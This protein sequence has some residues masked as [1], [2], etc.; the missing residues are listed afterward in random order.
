MSGTTFAQ[1]E[2]INAQ[3]RREYA[4]GAIQERRDHPVNLAQQVPGLKFQTPI[5]LWQMPRT[6]GPYHAT[7]ENPLGPPPT[8][9]K[10][11]AMKWRTDLPYADPNKQR[12]AILPALLLGGALL[13]AASRGP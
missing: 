1:E 2:A 6:H 13:Y 4:K 5:G 11:M 10:H 3:L 12:L 7:E 8:H 9:F